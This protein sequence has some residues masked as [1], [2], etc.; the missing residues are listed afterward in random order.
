M[1]ID[2]CDKARKIRES[3]PA[4]GL[5]EAKDWRVSPS[6][7]PISNQLASQLEKLGPLLLKFYT[8]ADL[9]YRRSHEGQLE[10]WIHEWLDKGKPSELIQRQRGRAFRAAVPR[11]IRPDLLLTEEGFAITELDSV[12]G[13]IG[14]TA[15]LNQTYSQFDDQVIGGA[16]GMV[17]GFASIFPDKA[18]VQIVVSEESKTYRPE[19]QWLANQLG[20]E[21]FTVTTEDEPLREE[22][23]AIYRFFELFDLKNIPI[24]SQLFERAE[25][26]QLDF[27]PPPKPVLEEKMLI[28][29]LHN[30]HLSDFWK[31]NLGTAYFER[32]KKHTP[33]SWVINPAPLPPHTAI[34]GLNL[35]NWETLKTLSQ[36]KRDLIV[37]ISGFS[38]TAWGARS[39][40]LGSDLP[41]EQWS[42]AIDEALNSFETNP[43]VL[44]RY[45]KPKRI[46]FEYH[47]SENKQLTSMDGRVRLCPY[48][49]VSYHSNQTKVKLG[50]ILA[51]VCPSDKKIIHGMK[52][53]IL[54]PCSLE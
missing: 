9:L 41:S 17:E 20:I 37:K 33:E 48:Y 30:V 40:S 43:F 31:Q 49:F 39:V 29:L 13:G 34:P 45:H 8:A 54:A 22:T 42:Q 7:F 28:A 50:G 38:E 23:T 12:P 46:S 2:R 36:K 16:N 10:P 19:M 53:A 4:Q 51:T 24:A 21:Q 1:N 11:V 6:P 3:I 5:F 14:L 27:T 18:K 25:A 44:Q 35:P 47:D 32:L 26:K 52:D 15:W